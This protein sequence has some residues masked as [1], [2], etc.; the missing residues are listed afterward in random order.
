MQQEKVC[1]KA[2]DTLIHR[3]GT[4]SQQDDSIQIL[5]KNCRTQRSDPENYKK[6]I[7]PKWGDCCS[8]LERATTHHGFSSRLAD[9]TS[10]TQ[11][12]I[13]AA[14]SSVSKLPEVSKVTPVGVRRQAKAAEQNPRALKFHQ[15]REEFAGLLHKYINP[16]MDELTKKNMR[17]KIAKANNADKRTIDDH[18][19][20]AMAFTHKEFLKNLMGLHDEFEAKA[21]GSGA[22]GATDV[23]GGKRKTRKSHK[24]KGKSHKAKGKSHKAK[25]KSHKRKGKRKTRK[26]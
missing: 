12:Q 13:R 1:K 8:E 10:L 19:A 23:K 14:L 7:E 26:H 25:G 11:D 16:D 18:G 22:T 6:F 20:T 15:D 21:Q 2:A 5:T 4:K 9:K 17:A 24:A 3:T